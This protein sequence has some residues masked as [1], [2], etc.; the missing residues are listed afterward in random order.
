MSLKPLLLLP[1]LSLVCLLSACAG[2][3]PKTD[4]NQA[5]IGLQAESPNDLLADRVDGKRLADGRYFQVAP[6]KHRL[7]MALL[8]GA[9]GNSVQPACMGRLDYSGFKAGERYQLVESSQGQ[10]VSAN[11]LDSHGQQVAQSD[12][13]KCL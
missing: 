8:Q 3:L 7:E 4:P 13:F 6:G 2:P 5:W 10:D 9:N 12:A 1:G 11:L